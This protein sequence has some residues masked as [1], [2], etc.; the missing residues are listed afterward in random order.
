MYHKSNQIDIHRIS[1]L[2][3][4]NLIGDCTVIV[5]TSIDI[6]NILSQITAYPLSVCVSSLSLFYQEKEHDQ[7]VEKV[8]NK[9]TENIQR[10]CLTFLKQ[11]RG[12]WTHAILIHH[13]LM[14]QWPWLRTTRNFVTFQS[15]KNQQREDVVCLWLS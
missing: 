9:S 3:K 14:L 11:E 2:Y 7:F 5:S 13:C 10:K 4:N 15:L 12:K 1:Y 6:L 8:A